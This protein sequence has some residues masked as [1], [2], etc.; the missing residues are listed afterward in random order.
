MLLQFLRILG[1]VQTVTVK[2]TIGVECVRYVGSLDDDHALSSVFNPQAW[3]IDA[4]HSKRRAFCCIW[5]HTLARRGTGVR[6]C[7]LREWPV[8]QAREDVNYWPIYPNSVQIT[9]QIEG[10]A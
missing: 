3:L 1:A 7:P 4:I 2:H 9:V 5:G 10:G 8:R 6:P